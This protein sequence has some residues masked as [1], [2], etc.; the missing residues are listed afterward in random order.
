MKTNKIIVLTALIGLASF[1]V[2][3]GEAVVKNSIRGRSG[4]VTV[5]LQEPVTTTVAIS[6]RGQGVGTDIEPQVAS[7]PHW[8]NPSRG[9]NAN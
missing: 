5:T 3:A 4:I 9:P 1:A 7:K 8:N 6:H 2:S